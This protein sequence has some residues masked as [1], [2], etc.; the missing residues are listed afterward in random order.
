MYRFKS[1]QREGLV[2]IHNLALSIKCH[3]LVEWQ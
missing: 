2:A 1:D 3:W